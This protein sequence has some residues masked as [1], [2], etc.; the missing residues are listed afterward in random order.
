[1]QVKKSQY[2]KVTDND[3]SKISTNIK[4]FCHKN[5]KRNKRKIQDY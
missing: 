4:K 1:M 5:E 3:I 2:P